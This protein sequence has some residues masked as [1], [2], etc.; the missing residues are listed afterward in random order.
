MQSPVA[1]QSWRRLKL[2]DSTLYVKLATGSSCTFIIEKG[3]NTDFDAAI[4]A[5]IKGRPG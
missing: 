2:A 4:F 1:G 5:E 3:K